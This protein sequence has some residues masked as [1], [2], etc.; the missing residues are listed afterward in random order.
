[1]NLCLP[2]EARAVMP[3]RT[4]VSVQARPAAQG[5]WRPWPL[6]VAA[7]LLGLGS[8]VQA[9]P[10]ALRAA[11][12]GE[13]ELQELLLLQRFHGDVLVDARRAASGAGAA[14]DAIEA[15]RRARQAAHERLHEGL[16]DAGLRVAGARH[17]LHDLEARREQHLQARQQLRDEALAVD[18]RAAELAGTISTARGE[19]QVLLRELEDLHGGVVDHATQT[20]RL[21]QSMA[22]GSH[23]LQ[24]RA[25]L[26]RD[27]F[28]ARV[29]AHAQQLSDERAAHG[30]AVQELQDW[31]AQEREALQAAQARIEAA[32]TA[33]EQRRTVAVRLREELS[34]AAQRHAADPPD[35]TGG[36]A[37]ADAP[38]RAEADD[39]RMR[40]TT[41]LAELETA[42]LEHERARADA[43]AA[44]ERMDAELDRRRSALRE[45]RAALHARSEA[46][47]AL[48]A[49]RRARVAFEL[50]ELERER[51]A[52]MVEARAGLAAAQEAL[53]TR[54]GERAAAL[55]GLVAAWLG[56]AGEARPM[57][58][59]DTVAWQGE[60]APG[61]VVLLQALSRLAAAAIDL[62]TVGAERQV[63]LERG[64]IL[65]AQARRLNASTVTL[66]QAVRGAHDAYLQRRREVVAALL[67]ADRDQRAALSAAAQD[68]EALAPLWRT[69]QARLHL[70]EIE[71]ARFR[72][73][74]LGDSGAVAARAE[75]RTA[76]DRQREDLAPLAAA[77]T[78]AA[79]AL[80]RAL[81]D[82]AG[83]AAAGHST[84]DRAA[85]RTLDATAATRLGDWLQAVGAA[86]PQWWPLSAG[87]VATEP[88]I[89]AR[90]GLLRESLA[91]AAEVASAA[92]GRLMLFLAH[93]VLVAT[94]P[95]GLAG[96]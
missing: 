64:D 16:R 11:M 56:E 80:L 65:D 40:F 66:Q 85:V 78:W 10:E 89:A 81:A 57:D 31:L 62:D 91:G 28:N 73:L 83:A 4:A 12:S 2:L 69:A 67:D 48:L 35:A 47:G 17:D 13:L 33:H 8:A 39:L 34:A 46:D 3:D 5:R 26:L 93:G 72:A 59:P 29:A 87:T 77:P 82:G 42:R 14:L 49:E 7:S 53:S 79:D 27:G 36:S 54:F 15:D 23:E 21:A 88:V 84:R 37:T 6:L 50:A 92:A 63:L 43:Q 95:A 45:A 94:P 30:R 71:F 1:M 32:A 90:R 38:R 9:M 75:L 51:A 61:A 18:A 19:V 60:T 68:D 58:L 44:V 74:L 25:A 52:L 76:L 55:H 96:A 20:H 41:T 22:A 24:Q 86:V 70:A